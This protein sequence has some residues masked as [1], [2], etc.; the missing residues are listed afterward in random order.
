M[1]REMLPKFS[2]EHKFFDNY[3]F[4][5]TIIEWNK[6]NLTLLNWESFW[7]FKTNIIRC[8]RQKPTSFLTSNIYKRIR[9]IACQS[10]IHFLLYCSIFNG[11]RHTLSSI[12]NNINCKILE[13]T[14]SSVPKTFLV[15]HHLVETSLRTHSLVTIDL[16]SETKGSRF[17]SGH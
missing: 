3:L 6:L 2:T 9:P 16:R 13:S 17:D 11:N 4:H 5:S 14:C 15:A 12:L 10:Q 1:L 8:I 7:V